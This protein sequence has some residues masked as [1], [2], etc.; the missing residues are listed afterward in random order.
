PSRATRARHP[1]P[2]RRSS[3]LDEERPSRNRRGARS[4]NTSRG[5]TTRHPGRGAPLLEDPTSRE[6]QDR[7]WAERD[8]STAYRLPRTSRRERDRK[9]TRLNSSHVKISYAV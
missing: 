4:R 5:W 3:D 6:R 1:F 7:L 8:R 9:S 2:T